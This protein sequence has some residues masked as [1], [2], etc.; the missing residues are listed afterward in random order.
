MNTAKDLFTRVLTRAR[1][2]TK[3]KSGLFGLLSDNTITVTNLLFS[4]VVVGLQLLLSSELF[5]C[6]LENHV[7][8]GVMFLVAPFF[9]VLIMNILLIGD[10]W[11]V[12][13]R[14]CV[15]YY[16][17]NPDYKRRLGCLIHLIPNICKSFVGP[18]VWLIASFVDGKYVACFMVGQDIEKRNLTDDMEIE[19]L[20]AEF[21]K[22]KAWSHISAWIAFLGLVLG[23]AV[24]MTTKK[25]WLKDNVLLEGTV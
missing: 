7:C 25:C 3:S 11:K 10:V 16:N 18:F 1:D 15:P 13:D 5:D 2:E 9:I 24:L 8:Y 6:P 20:E 12:T 4:A 17:R 14:C 21:A 22:A 23:T 19:K